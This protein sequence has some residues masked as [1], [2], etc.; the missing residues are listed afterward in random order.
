MSVL[1]LSHPAGQ[2]TLTLRSRYS[3]LHHY[4]QLLLP[5]R[6]VLTLLPVYSKGSSVSAQPP[7]EMSPFSSSSN[8]GLLSVNSFYRH[9]PT[10]SAHRPDG[11]HLVI[12]LRARNLRVSPCQARFSCTPVLSSSVSWG[13]TQ[14]LLPSPA[15][16]SAPPL[17]F[18]L[19]SKPWQFRLSLPSQ[20]SASLPSYESALPSTLRIHSYFQSPQHQ[21]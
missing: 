14:C 9:I 12:V 10:V 17:L 2:P 19:W 5:D 21:P 3:H 11:C 15:S 7:Q 8:S 18:S 6:N 16:P 13:H 20:P 4:K 1:S